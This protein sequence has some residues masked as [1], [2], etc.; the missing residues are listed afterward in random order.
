LLC[1]ARVTFNEASSRFIEL[2]V[3]DITSYSFNLVQEILHCRCIRYR[4]GKDYI[5]EEI[6]PIVLKE[7][8]KQI[9][10]GSDRLEHFELL[11]LALTISLPVNIKIDLI[12]SSIEAIKY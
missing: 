6:V 1:T 3:K 12:Q 10:A 7:T 2:L 11:A 5:K 9:N 4:N 8:L